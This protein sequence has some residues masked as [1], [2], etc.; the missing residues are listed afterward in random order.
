MPRLKMFRGI[1]SL[2]STPFDT[3]TEDCTCLKVTSW[4]QKISH[5]GSCHLIRSLVSRVADPGDL[6][7]RISKCLTDVTSYNLFIHEGYLVRNKGYIFN[8]A[9]WASRRLFKQ[10]SKYVFYS[11]IGLVPKKLKFQRHL[12]GFG[13]SYRNL[14]IVAGVERRT[15][16]VHLFSLLRIP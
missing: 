11:Y 1:S 16:N 13:T 15:H 7:T 6:G 8:E 9:L 14:Y 10:D 4:A 3:H 12:F 5:C 2:P